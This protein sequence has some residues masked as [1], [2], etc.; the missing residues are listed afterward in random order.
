MRIVSF[1][2][3][4]AVVALVEVLAPKRRLTVAKTGRWLN[5]LGIILID[6]LLVR[7]V[8]PVAAMGG[9]V[10]ARQHGWGVLNIVPLPG[11]LSVILAVVVLDLVI[12][13]QHVMFH[14]VPVLWRLHMV[15]H[16]DLDIDVTTGLRFHPVEILISML[17]K[18]AAVFVIGP[19]VEAVLL[20][21]ILLN[22]S[23]MFNHGNIA[24]P[25]KV[26]RYLRLLLV[27]P[28]MH[29]VH[30][31]VIRRETN[32]NYGFNLSCWDRLFGTY[33][34]QPAKG[35]TGMT[36]GLSRFRRP[37][38]VTLLRLLLMPVLRR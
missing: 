17:I 21:E 25:E 8:F 14:I 27:T 20:F 12:Y 19:P 11:W 2:F 9:A 1:F 24:L 31:S 15:H 7:L 5:N 35:H 23:A 30:H 38:Q 16:A 13:L 34:A 6:S 18:M 32:S 26:D 37:E 33:R 4:L 3:V 10:T 22:G 36:I 28:D 29:R